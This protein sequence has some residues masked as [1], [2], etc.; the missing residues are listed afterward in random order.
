M[1]DLEE[2]DH[3]MLDNEHVNTNELHDVLHCMD[4]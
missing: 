3:T 4:N 1:N 2:Y